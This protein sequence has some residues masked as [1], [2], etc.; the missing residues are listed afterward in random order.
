MEPCYWENRM[1]T[2][3]SF[4][5]ITLS[6]LSLACGYGSNYMTGGGSMP[7]IAK[8]NPANVTAGGPAF[9]LM[10][11]GSNFG[12]QAVVNWNGVAQTSNTTYVTSTQLTVSVPAALVANPGTIQV[13]V[14]NPGT[15]GKGMYGGS[16]MPQT[17]LPMM[18][19]I[20]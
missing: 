13:T 8:L 12:A 3:V 4:V 17:S 2:A 19:T 5:L 7:A 11:S 6:A 20:D 16:T 15:N 10:V 9:T 1:K 18:F 14:T